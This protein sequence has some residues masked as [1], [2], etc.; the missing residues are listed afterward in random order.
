MGVDVRESALSLMILQNSVVERA[1]R[2]CSWAQWSIFWKP[3]VPA[4]PPGF[5]W[6][7]S[8]QRRKPAAFYVVWEG[9]RRGLFYRWRDCLKSVANY[10]GAQFMGFVTLSEAVDAY[11]RGPY[12]RGVKGNFGSSVE[13]TALRQGS[14]F[15]PIW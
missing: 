4:P 10:D 9:R 8:V 15:L 5:Q 12:S 7:S 6:A 13:P 3:W 1:Q 14:K 11:E 2:R